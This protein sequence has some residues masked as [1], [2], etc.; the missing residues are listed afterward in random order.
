MSK[1]FGKLLL[2]I[3][4]MLVLFAV[5][6]ASEAKSATAGGANV[7]IAFISSPSEYVSGQI[8][9]YRIRVTNPDA[10][11]RTIV[12]TFT[13]GD[14]IGGKG[15]PRADRT[16]DLGANESR[17]ITVRAM[18]RDSREYPG[19][20]FCFQAWSQKRDLPGS[21]SATTCAVPKNK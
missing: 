16:L 17:V 6:Q 5:W 3:L 13:L 12:V 11:A 15:G 14:A 10:D 2:L 21:S 20:W 4:V 8:Y 18:A 9:S 7:P 19:A 1:S